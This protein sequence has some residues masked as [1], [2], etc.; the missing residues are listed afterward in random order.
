M[1]KKDAEWTSGTGLLS[2]EMSLGTVMGWCHFGDGHAE[3]R[4]LDLDVVIHEL[5][6]M[7]QRPTTEMDK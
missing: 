2:S 5:V 1:D 7:Q 4:G 6:D 3:L